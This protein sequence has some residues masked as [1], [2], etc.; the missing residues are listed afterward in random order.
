M[1]H[2]SSSIKPDN[3]TQ[4]PYDFGNRSNFSDLRPSRD[5]DTQYNKNTPDQSSKP[6]FYLLTTLAIPSI[7]C[8]FFLFVNFIRLPHLRTKSINI[9]IIL[10]LT[11]DFIHVSYLILYFLKTKT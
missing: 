1:S 9:I 11:I 4:N 2:L 6:M 8:F 5:N 10:L 7:M 3:T